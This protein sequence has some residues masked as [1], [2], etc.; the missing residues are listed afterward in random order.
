LENVV[1]PGVTRRLLG[2][3]GLHR[4]CSRSTGRARP[5]VSAGRA[6]ERTTLMTLRSRAPSSL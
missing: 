4:V 1:E 3:P 2:R 6:V 5:R